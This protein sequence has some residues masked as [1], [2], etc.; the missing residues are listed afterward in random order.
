MSDFLEH[1]YLKFCVLIEFKHVFTAAYAAVF[2]LSFWAYYT[3][4]MSV[5]S[6]SLCMLCIVM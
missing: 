5:S 4:N 2:R 1:W 6:E 3:A